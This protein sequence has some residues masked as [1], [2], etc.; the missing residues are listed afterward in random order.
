MKV[1]IIKCLQDNY[2]YLVI[3]ETNDVAIVIDPSDSRPIIDI[4]RKIN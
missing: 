3:D 4:L 1:E 2:A